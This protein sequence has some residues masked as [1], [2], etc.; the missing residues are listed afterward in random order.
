MLKQVSGCARSDRLVL[1]SSALC[2]VY[3]SL[4][5]LQV[6]Q[7]PTLTRPANLTVAS[8]GKFAIRP[9][10]DDLYHILPQREQKVIDVFRSVLRDGDTVVDLGANIGFFSI[11]GARLV[12][13]S[14]RVIAVEMMPETVERLKINVELNGLANVRTIE[15]ALADRSGLEVKAHV[16]IGRFGQASLVRGGA[17]ASAVRLRTRTLDEMCGD[18]GKIAMIKMDVEGAELL[19]IKGG[20]ET[21]L[22]T[23]C[24]VFEELANEP[25]PTAVMRE[26]EKLGFRISRIDGNN[27]AAYRD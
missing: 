26:L 8:V 19:I 7:N 5:E 17:S 9:N 10:C 22:R 16:P 11:L 13:E 15:A 20:R 2:G 27:F 6:W 25:S 4:Q 23:Q 12:S 1:I 3:T 18:L 14:G 21:F 24:V